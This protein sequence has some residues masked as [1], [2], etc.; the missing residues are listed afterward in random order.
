MLYS[1]KMYENGNNT[2]IDDC[3]STVRSSDIWNDSTVISTKH[4]STKPI[5][6]WL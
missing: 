4:C 3:D 1:M 5:T 6:L 2:L